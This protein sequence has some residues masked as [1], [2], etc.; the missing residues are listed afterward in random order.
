MHAPVNGAI[1][2][3]ESEQVLRDKVPYAAAPLFELVSWS[4]KW[5]L[6]PVVQLLHKLNFVFTTVTAGGASEFFLNAKI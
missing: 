2:H 1:V 4:Y 5:K 3:G 6:V